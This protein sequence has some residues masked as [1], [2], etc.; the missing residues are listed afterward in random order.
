VAE[1][2]NMN[3]LYKNGNSFNYV[4]NSSLYNP[5][6]LLYFHTGLCDTYGYTRFNILREIFGSHVGEDVDVDR[7]DL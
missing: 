2:F 3:I 5:L 6:R 1:Y 4:R 7:I